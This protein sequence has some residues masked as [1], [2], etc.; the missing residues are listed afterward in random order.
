LSSSGATS[1]AAIVAPTIPI[2]YKVINPDGTERR[3]TRV[4]KKA[5]RNNMVHE[6]RQAIEALK[7]QRQQQQQETEKR[8]TKK[9]KR[10]P[11]QIDT[12]AETKTIEDKEDEE[13]LSKQQRLQR[14]GK[15]HQLSI[16]QEFLED[17]LAEHR[18]HHRRG[19][20]KPPV[21]LS[22]PMARFASAIINMN[23][24]ATTPA[25]P[26]VVRS[27]REE[28]GRRLATIHYDHQL[29]EQWAK[30]L[31]DSMIPA[32]QVREAEDMRPMAY[33]LM[34]EAWMRLRPEVTI[35]HPTLITTTIHQQSFQNQVPTTTSSSTT[36][37]TNTSSLIKD[38][39]TP[40]TTTS[41]VPL[42]CRPPSALDVATAVVFEYLYKEMEYH[43]SCGAKFGADFLLYDGPRHKRHAFGGLR[44]VQQVNTYE[45]KTVLPFLST[46]EMA[47]YVRCLNTAGK[48][49]LLATVVV[50]EGEK[51]DDP[52]IFKVAFVDLALEKILTA[53]THQRFGRSEKRRDVAKNL[54]KK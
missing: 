20:G 31:K 41:W 14:D 5:A 46:Y 24:V 3:M 39:T 18:D 28:E 35:S 7:Q 6:K 45:T 30:S 10:I 42:T 38:P 32:E 17:E 1:A 33:Q 2:T 15:Y 25:D 51:E 47:A 37:T 21:L 54:A 8:E 40:Y 29:S 26:Q 43:M 36:T 53:P 16:K 50:E 44:I 12:Q 34:P 22:P 27:V 9:Q 11:I 49:A 19:E 52:V 13:S 4:E 23:T 48:L